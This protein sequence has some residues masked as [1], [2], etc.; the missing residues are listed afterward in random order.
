MD[1][2]RNARCGGGSRSESS[3][4]STGCIQLATASAATPPS[5][6]KREALGQ[7]VA[8]RAVRA[9][10]AEAEPNRHL[11]LARRGS[12]EQQARRGWRT[13]SAAR[14]RPAPS[15]E[16]ASSRIGDGRARSLSG[17]ARCGVAVFRP[18]ATVRRG[19]RSS[20][21]RA[22]RRWPRPAG[23]SARRLTAADDAD[24]PRL[25]I[26]EQRRTAARCRASGAVDAGER[27][28]AGVGMKRDPEV[29]QLT[30]LQAEEGRW[31]DAD[32]RD[33]AAV[34]RRAAGRWRRDRRR[35][36][37]ARS[38]GRPRRPAPRLRDRPRDRMSARGTPG[39]RA[40]PK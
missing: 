19:D 4:S 1:S 5:C 28:V 17:S 34:D 21:E 8:G 33:R 31:R 23:H 32:D 39:R 38:D 11:A 20:G 29:G 9:R 36:A 35:G 15:A 40:C 27:R 7:R 18:P 24:E 6:G 37:A 25:R 26:G 2:R 12:L 13:R 3:R 30:G 22:A 10:Y 14:R 16:R